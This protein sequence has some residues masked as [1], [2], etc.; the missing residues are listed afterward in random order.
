MDNVLASTLDRLLHHAPTVIPET[1]FEHGF[2]ARLDQN[3]QNSQTTQNNNNDDD[4]IGNN[5]LSN[6]INNK[7]TNSNRNNN[8]VKAGTTIK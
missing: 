2:H 4:N 5:P 7:A 6:K 8:N 1:P 3:L